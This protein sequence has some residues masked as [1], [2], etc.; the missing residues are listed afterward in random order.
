MNL[1]ERWRAWRRDRRRIRSIR[2]IRRAT[3]YLEHLY[4]TECRPWRYAI[5]GGGGSVNLG[6]S[7]L[8]TALAKVEEAGLT[9]VH[10]DGP[11]AF[12]AVERRGLNGRPEATPEIA[13]L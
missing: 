3:E 7:D 9:P 11:Q 4:E 10:V 6:F 2:R 1:R 12:I 5:V 8:R 13:S